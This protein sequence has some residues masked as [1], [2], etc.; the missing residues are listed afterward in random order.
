[1]IK[2]DIAVLPM[3][4]KPGNGRGGILHAMARRTPPEKRGWFH[5]LF[6][7]D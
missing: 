6:A 1:M 2:K 3:S 7:K 5:R 4:E